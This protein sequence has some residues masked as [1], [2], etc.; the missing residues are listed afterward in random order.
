MDPDS[1]DI[2]EITVE[3]DNRIRCLIGLKSG[4]SLVFTKQDRQTK[5]K[6]F[7]IW[8]NWL[9]KVKYMEEFSFR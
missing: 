4:L 2:R 3:V 8:K 7:I 1:D 9:R 5:N 6:Y